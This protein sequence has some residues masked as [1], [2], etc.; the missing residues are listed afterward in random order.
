MRRIISVFLMLVLLLSLYGCGKNIQSNEN[1]KKIIEENGYDAEISV[2]TA[3]IITT[4][5]LPDNVDGLRNSDKFTLVLVSSEGE[6]AQD[7]NIC[8]VDFENEKMMIFEYGNAFPLNVLADEYIKYSSSRIQ[9]QNFNIISTYIK[10]YGFN[11]AEDSYCADAYIRRITGANGFVPLSEAQGIIDGAIKDYLPSFSSYDY[12]EAV[13][14]EGSAVINSYKCSSEVDGEN[15][16][17][18]YDRDLNILY[19]SYGDELSEIGNE[20]EYVYD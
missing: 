8:A 3:E 20:E 15:V 2:S 17:T 6:S 19:T 16:I 1:L 14:E 9:Q 13:F 11:F 4:S 12:A 7:Y 18:M 5:E 10:E